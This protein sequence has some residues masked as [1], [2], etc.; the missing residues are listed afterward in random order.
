MFL[1]LSNASYTID[2]DI[3][4]RKLE[5]YVIRGIIN[6]LFKAYLTNRTQFAYI[7]RYRSSETTASYGV[8]QS[9]ILAPLLFLFYINDTLFATILHCIYYADISTVFTRGDCIFELQNWFNDELSNVFK[10]LCANYL[11]LTV[12]KSLFYCACKQ[13]HRSHACS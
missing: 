10:W 6:V 12:E 2:H 11:Y 9:S 8:P 7:D 5:Y 4:C 1:D 13:K 3:F